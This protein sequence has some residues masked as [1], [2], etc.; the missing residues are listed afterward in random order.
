MKKNPKSSYALFNLGI[1]YYRIED[2]ESALSY[3]QKAIQTE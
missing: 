3:F 2:L 1:M